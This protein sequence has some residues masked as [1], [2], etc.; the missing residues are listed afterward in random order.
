MGFLRTILILILFYYAFKLI[1][2][3]VLPY[4]ASR[5]VKKAQENFNQQQGNID[6]EEAKKREGEVNFT[7]KSNSQ[8]KNNNSKEALGDYIEFEEISED[9]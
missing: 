9:K 2:R 3:M 6:P 8:N 7:S 4:L 5:W 1:V